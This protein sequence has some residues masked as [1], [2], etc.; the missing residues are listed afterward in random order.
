MADLTGREK[1]LLAALE[2]ERAARRKAEEALRAREELLALVAHDLRNLAWT[3]TMSATLLA[4]GRPSLERRRNAP[5][6]DAIRRAALRMET[7]LD[8]LR[9]VGMMDAGFFRVDPNP[10][11][12]APILGEAVAMWRPL[13]EAKAI[14]LELDAEPDMPWV[15][16]DK[17]RVHQVLGNLV[18]NAIEHTPDG[19]DV[20]LAARLVGR[21]VRVSVKDS[22]PGI[23]PSF[24]PRVFDR[25]WRK[26]EPNRRGT[27]LGL[28]IARGIVDRLG[29]RL[30]VESEAGAGTTFSFTL[31]L[32]ATSA[33]RAPSVVETADDAAL[34]LRVRASL[35]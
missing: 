18:G 31:P 27:G 24:L 14:R 17:E 22:G 25:Y 35:A 6:V 12:L 13:A 9:D 8:A 2:A 5:S 4:K 10:D 11:D 1:E 20:R 26:N 29:G 3:I 19:G 30:W 28:F 21:E 15:A 32:A 16:L 7:L 34:A 23:A 33:A